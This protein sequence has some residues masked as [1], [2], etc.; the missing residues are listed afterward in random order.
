[1]TTKTTQFAAIGTDGTRPVVWGL[2]ATEDEAEEDAR[3]QDDAG[4][5]KLITVEVTAEQAARIEAGEVSVAT[6]GIAL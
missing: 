6:L 3:A 5:V 2:G 4:D 1:M